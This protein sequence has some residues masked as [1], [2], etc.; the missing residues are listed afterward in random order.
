[1]D[2]SV[3]YSVLTNY[4]SWTKKVTFVYTTSSLAVIWNCWLVGIWLKGRRTRADNMKIS[5]E[6]VEISVE[7]VKI[8]VDFIVCDC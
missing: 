8:S 4:G 3:E 6:L 1:M 2:V 7:L 5:V